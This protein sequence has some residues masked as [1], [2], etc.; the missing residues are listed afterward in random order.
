MKNCIRAGCLATLSWK[1]CF[2]FEC[3]VFFLCCF[4]FIAL[5]SSSQ[6]S[7]VRLAAFLAALPWHAAPSGKAEGGRLVLSAVDS[8]VYSTDPRLQ[9]NELTTLCHAAAA[10]F[11]RG[12]RWPCFRARWFAF[13]PTCRSR[14][15]HSKALNRG[16]WCSSTSSNR[17]RPSAARRGLV[18]Y[19]TP[20]SKSL[21]S[22]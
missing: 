9:M 12:G 10:S 14:V 1:C 2:F 6:C 13:P 17:V 8:S 7:L 20:A 15:D 22:D 4:F 16:K 21:V 19:P 11:R 3:L 18:N 5:P